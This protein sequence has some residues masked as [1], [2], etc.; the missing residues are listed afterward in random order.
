MRALLLVL[1]TACDAGKKPAPTPPSPPAG[2]AS[3]IAD[4]AP[5]AT[6]DAGTTAPDAA[7][8]DVPAAGPDDIGL[9]WVV[10]PPSVPMKRDPQI[11]QQPVTLEITAGGATKATK[12]APQFGG[13][14]PYNQ[15]ACKGDAYPLA[16]GELAKLTFYEGGAG[17][18]IVRRKGDALVVYSWAQTDG[19]CGTVE[20]PEEC[21]RNEK[22]VASV[23]AQA[24]SGA[25]IVER[26]VEVD[27]KGARKPFDCSAR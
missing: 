18:Y 12:L 8:V 9:T 26:I 27:D 10:Y 3:I 13:L 23:A 1:L 25:K 16:K 24:K 14:Q 19:L 11:L 20:K 2:S 21:P 17:G 4:A 7:V 6:I 15:S 22:Q 5:V